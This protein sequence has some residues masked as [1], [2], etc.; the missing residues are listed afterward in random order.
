M[1]CS[2]AI[3]SPRDT[4][5]EEEEGADVDGAD[6]D[7]AEWEGGVAPGCLDLNYAL[8]RFTVAASMADMCV[9]WS[10]TRKG[11]EKWRRICVIAEGKMSLSRD[12]ESR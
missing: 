11:T 9:K 6:L 12:T 5:L 10:D 8:L 3:I 4:S 1:R 7:G 2:C